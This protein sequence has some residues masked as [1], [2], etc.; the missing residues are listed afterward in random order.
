LLYTKALLCGAEKR[1]SNPRDFARPE[2][3]AE[4]PRAKHTTLNASALSSPESLTLALTSDSLPNTILKTLVDSGSSDSFID[5]VFVQTQHLPAY[6]IPPIKLRLIDGTCNSVITQALDL[7]IHFPTGES[8]KLTFYVTPLDQSC[9]I[10][11]GYRWLTRYNLLIDW[12]LGSIAFRQPSHP[13]SKTSPSVEAVTKPSAPLPSLQEPPVP[14]IMTPVPPVNHGKPRITLINAA[15]YARVCK[16]KGTTR[17]QLRV[18]LPEVTGR[19]TT[20][21]DLPVD[22]NHVP[23]EY[24]AFADVFS[25]TKAGKLAEHRPYDLKITLDEGTTPPFGPIYSLSQEELAA[26]RKFIDENLATGFIRP[27]RSP[28]GAP[29]LFIRKKDGSL[30]LCVDF[31]GLNRISKKDRYPLPLISDLL[32]APRKARIYTKIDLRHAYHL[33]R[34]SAGDE[35]KTAFRTR[36]GSFEWLVMPEGLTNAPAAFQRFMNDIFSDMTD[37]SVI[38]YLDDILVYSDNLSEHQQHVTE[39]F[40]RLRANNL[41]ARAD[42]CEFHVTSCKYLGYM[43]SPEGLTMA[44]YKVQVIQDWPELRKVRDIQSFLGFANFYRRFI[45][46]YSDITVPLTRLTRKGTPWNFSD[47]CRTAFNMLK[48]AF[49]TAPVL[50]HWMPDTPITVETDAS[51]YALAAVLSIT[52]PTS[53]KMHPIAFHSRTFSEPERNY[54]V[55]D[56][57]LLAIFEAFKRWRHYLEGSGTPIDVVTDHRN[58][59]YFSMTKILTRRQARWSEY[60]SGFH[61]IIRFRPGKL[62]TKPDALTR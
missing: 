11:L 13:D 28:C 51:D 38:V 54:D 60:L 37:I 47:E 9:T 8:Q 7:H 20:T 26:L 43:L 23:E 32:D 29:V 1:L 30:R 15:A 17:F 62:G 46:G 31:R 35:W 33:I 34:I 39:V 19:S 48:K 55:H 36:Y 24:H 16:L 5:T 14:R 21:S 59:Q 40:R 45:Y 18:S 6:G 57:E 2:D 52:T 4:L 10:V 27:S 50:T 53:G 41:F 25:K 12:V 61:L 22:L 49:T 56:K 44:P 58:L 3:C 42:K